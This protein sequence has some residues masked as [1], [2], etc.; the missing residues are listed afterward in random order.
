MNTIGFVI[1]DSCL[2][3]SCRRVATIGDGALVSSIMCTRSA[4]TTYGMLIDLICVLC[5]GNGVDM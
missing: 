4:G 5:Y 1:S 3:A 2:R